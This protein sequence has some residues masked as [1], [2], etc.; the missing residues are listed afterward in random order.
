VSLSTALAAFFALGFALAHPVWFALGVLVF[1]T[2]RAAGRLARF[3]LALAGA[4]VAC[5]LAAAVSFGKHR[6]SLSAHRVDRAFLVALIGA[7][8]AFVGHA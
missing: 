6:P 5:W 1:L 3:Y 8:P 2:A 7:R 4:R